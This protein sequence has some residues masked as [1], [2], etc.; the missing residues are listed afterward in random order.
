M[1]KLAYG[2]RYGAPT[3]SH[4]DT[5]MATALSWWATQHYGRVLIEFA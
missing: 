1:T 2:W 5:V 3:G 4:D